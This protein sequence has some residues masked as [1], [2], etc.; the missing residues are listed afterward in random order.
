MQWLNRLVSGGLLFSAFVLTSA[1]AEPPTTAEKPKPA[2]SRVE[3]A[4]TV[5]N[6]SSA[7]DTAIQPTAPTPNDAERLTPAVLTRMS[8]RERE[9]SALSEQLKKLRPQIAAMPAGPAQVEAKKSLTNMENRYAS[10]HLGQVT[11][12]LVWLPLAVPGGLVR[13]ANRVMGRALGNPDSSGTML[14]PAEAPGIGELR[15]VLENATD[16]GAAAATV[17]RISR[18]MTESQIKKEAEIAQLKEALEKSSSALETEDQAMRANGIGDIEINRALKEKDDAHE[19]LAEAT[20]NRIAVLDAELEYL[21]T[22]K[23]SATMFL[24]THGAEIPTGMG[25]IGQGAID[26]LAGNLAIGAAKMAGGVAIASPAGLDVGCWAGQCLVWGPTKG[27]VNSGREM[28]AV[29][30][31]GL[32]EKLLYDN[33][34][35][36]TP[37]ELIEMLTKAGAP[38]VLSIL[39]KGPETSVTIL[40]K[41][42][43]KAVTLNLT[44]KDNGGMHLDGM[45]VHKSG[46]AD[47]DYK[48]AM[49]EVGKLGWD[50]KDAFKHLLNDAMDPEQARRI[51]ATNS[52]FLGRG[53]IQPVIRYF[54]GDEKGELPG[55]V[56]GTA[57]VD[58]DK[59]SY[60]IE[61]GKVRV[62]NHQELKP[63][64]KKVG[65]YLAPAGRMLAPSLRDAWSAIGFGLEK[66]GH[67]GEVA[68]TKGIETAQA[69]QRVVASTAD[70]VAQGPIGQACF[71]GWKALSLMNTK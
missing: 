48:M 8:Q 4:E 6:G 13:S 68:I 63:W 71:A 30:G 40:N 29:R 45:S 14:R 36:K 27:L 53:I 44:L 55:F 28:I 59:V 34:S 3:S 12:G 50:V 42:G 54:E 9:M 7:S 37:A 64:L 35:K 57:K 5:R 65:A 43:E 20:R 39:T 58:G 61:P 49:E 67:Y 66:T 2:P 16:L 32:I 25:L 41:K 21:R 18:E 62:A 38:E 22:I 46:L 31:G 70:A 17:R 1:Y 23:S 19:K 69:T 11:D 47:L 15:E 56:R 33:A 26:M 10:L 24:I 51:S 52:S 60:E